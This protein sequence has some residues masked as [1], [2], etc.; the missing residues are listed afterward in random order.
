MRNLT[1]IVQTA[2]STAKAMS[3]MPGAIASISRLVGGIGIM[4]IMLVP[5]T[6]RTREIGIRMAVGAQQRD[7]LLQFLVEAL[8][9]CVMG[10][11]AGV[12]LGVSLAYAMAQTWGMAAE[13]TLNSILLAFVFSAVIGVFFGFYP[14]RRAAS[15]RPVEAL[16]Y[17]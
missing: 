17:E 14:A 1:A 15:L 16:R 3:F 5:V 13:V 9:I 7:I 12:L 11:L 8:M 2:A 10:G 6:E 4:N